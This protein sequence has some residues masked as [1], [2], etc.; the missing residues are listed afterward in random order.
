[1]TQSTLDMETG[2]TQPTPKSTQTNFVDLAKGQGLRRFGSVNWLG[3]WTFY[4]K[5]VQRFLKV[6]FQTVLAPVVTTLL[7]LVVFTQAF[8]DA[9]PAVNGVSFIVFLAPGLTM[10]AILN[11]AFSN[12]SSSLII[13]KI[14]GSIIDILMAPLSAAELTVGYTVGAAT[15]GLLVGFIT[16]LTAAGYMAFSTPLPINNLFAIIYFSV[17]ASVMFGLIG[18][19]GGVWAEKF[20]QLAAITNFIIMPLTFLSGTFYPISRLPEPFL[21]ITTFNPIFMLIDGFRYG[22]TGHAE[23]SVLTSTLVILV[24]NIILA[25]VCYRLLKSGW[26]IKS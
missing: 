10:M 11:N 25:F 12:S 19:V 2:A 9:R 3:L 17:S 24:I 5:E 1:M 14:Q 13:G 8:G 22:F 16:A 23:A 6:A 18:I 20:D 15:R 7:Y 21:T 4:K 26:R